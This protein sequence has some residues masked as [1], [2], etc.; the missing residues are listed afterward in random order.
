MP[1]NGRPR[2]LILGGGFAGVGAANELEH[3]DA[4]VV[5]VDR[6]DY[7]TFQ[8]LLYQLATGLLEQTAVG[9]SLRDLVEERLEGV[10]VVCLDQ[11]DVH[12][13]VPELPRCAH[14]RE[15]APEDDNDRTPSPLGPGVDRHLDLDASPPKRAVVKPARR[16]TRVN[17][18]DRVS[19]PV[20]IRSSPTRMRTRP[21]R[22]RAQPAIDTM[23]PRKSSTP[24]AGP[25]VSTA[26]ATATS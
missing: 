13:G 8:P 20:I 11:N 2:V 17:R 19:G 26:V 6:H 25:I 23:S 18:P 4:D 1:S 15:A 22:R 9:H 3:A 10:V 16:L 7:H 14:A 24:P 21:A 12:L 5:L